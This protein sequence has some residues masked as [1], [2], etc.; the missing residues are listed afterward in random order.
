MSSPPENSLQL[1]VMDIHQPLLPSTDLSSLAEACKEWGFFHIA[2]HGIS[3]EFYRKL[4]SL[5][6]QVF[7]LPTD[8]KLRAGPLSPI[9]AYT[10]HFIAS[11]F[12]ESLRVSGPD[13]YSSAKGSADVLFDQQETN[14]EFCRMFLEYGTRMA[15]LSARI[16]RVLL[17]CLGDDVEKKYYEAEFRRCH[18]YL[19]VNSYSPP[20]DV[21]EEEEGVEGLGM[22]TDMSCITIL[23]QDEIGGLQ[24]RSREGGW[25]DIQPCEGTLVV[26]IGDL[27]QAWSNGQL[28][29]SQHR[30]VLRQPVSRFSLAFFWCFEDDK[31][32]EAPEEVVGKGSRK[33][34]RP[35]VCL[36]YVRFRETIE[37]GRF[38]KVGYTVDDFA[39]A[40]QDSEGR[41]LSIANG[42]VEEQRESKISDQTTASGLRKSRR[43]TALTAG[44][45]E[46]VAE[47]S[48]SGVKKISACDVEALKRCLD[49]HK[50]DYKKCQTEVEAFKLSCSFKKPSPSQDHLKG[51]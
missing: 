23:Y 22:H 6:H 50:G 39:A 36:D 44:S 49:E 25:V 41:E 30:V 32:V 46:S 17:S 20:G 9:R 40:L 14:T 28:R 37:K 8:A 10:P 13:Y 16:V 35:F 45:M 33:L 15:E 26:N 48:E 5:S 21:Q 24:V 2:N 27:L 7:S 19:R 38:E 11:P 34:Y 42:G 1:P 51:S 18:G 47:K 43:C 31:V 3:E 12:F 29:S 4:R